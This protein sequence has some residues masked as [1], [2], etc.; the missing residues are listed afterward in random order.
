MAEKMNEKIEKEMPATGKVPAAPEAD[1][2]EFDPFG[3]I[4]QSNEEEI[5]LAAPDQET[6]YPTPVMLNREARKGRNGNIYYDYFAGVTGVLNGKNVLHKVRFKLADEYREAYDSVNLLFGDKVKIPLS[7]VR[8][9][10]KDRD[11]GAKRVSYRIQISA[12]EEDGTNYAMRMQP[13]DG[14]ARLEFEVLLSKLRAKGM[15]V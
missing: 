5:A 1:K 14:N 13:Y 10:M 6:V 4:P 8:T 11:T 3:D 15:I 2:N 7:I 12:I 9:E